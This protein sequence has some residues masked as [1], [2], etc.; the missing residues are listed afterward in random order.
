MLQIQTRS[1]IACIALLLLL[2][3]CSSTGMNWMGSSVRGTYNVRDFG[4]KGDGKTIDSPAIN[5]AI[6][7]ADKRGGGTIYFPPGTYLSYSIRLKSNITLDIEQ[8]ATILA[9]ESSAVE[10]FDRY[11]APEPNEH[12][13]YQDYGHS[14]WHNSLIW[15]EKIHNV[16]IVGH[17]MIDGK[18]LSRG[19][20]PATQPATQPVVPPPPLPAWTTTRLWDEVRKSIG[21]TTQ[22]STAPMV[23]NLVYPNPEDTLFAGIGNKAIAL[24]ECRN[25]TF[26]DFSMYRGGHFCMLLTGVDNLTIDNIK[27][28]TQR[29]GIDI[30]CCQNV[31]MS[32]CYVNSPGD[33]G[34]CLKSSYGMGYARATE[35]V[36]ITN[37]Q[38]SGYDVGTLLDGTFKRSALKEPWRGGGTG[39]IKFGTESNGGFKNISIS[40]CV[41]SNC[42]GLALETVDGG[43]LEDVSISNITMRDVTSSAFFFRLGARLRGPDNPKPGTL[44]RVNIDNVVIYNANPYYGSILSGIPG[45]D[46]EDIRMDNIRIVYAGGGP[47]ELATSRPSER[48]EEYPEPRMFG[49]IPAYGFYIRH[50]KN[51]KM[52]N[53]DLSYIEPD[54]RPAFILE[55][56]KGA[57]F[58]SVS[59]EHGEG[60][61]T[62]ILRNVERFRTDRVDGVAD[63]KADRVGD[64]QF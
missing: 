21:P 31:R 29:D 45:Y 46:L 58:H 62:F 8:N 43:Q 63:M 4:A 54:A 35:N 6:E 32:N 57:D 52:S 19:H 51:L 26:R 42:R 41:F 17:G 49:Y 13:K 23:T 47:K 33:D 30:D 16:A 9:A 50:V 40:N 60:V 37:C 39:R 44:K 48:A 25:V 3:G 64:E 38:V 11:D 14:H 28:D 20:K 36:T 12:N 61:P 56:V 7:Y 15:G 22:P 18:G 10:T 27:I 53:I 5:K 34:I 55:D 59:A 1:M 24:K 2:T